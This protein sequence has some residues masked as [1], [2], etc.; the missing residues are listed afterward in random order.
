MSILAKS[1]F[2]ELVDQTFK[3]TSGDLSTELKLAQVQT[4]SHIPKGFESYTLVFTGP[5]EPM[6]EQAIYRF[7]ND[8]FEAAD[9]FIVPVAGDDDGY[10]YELVV[11][12]KLED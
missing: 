4:P 6:L 12:R 3:V 2:E 9:L 1:E 8:N 11:N 5:K 7:E 10:D